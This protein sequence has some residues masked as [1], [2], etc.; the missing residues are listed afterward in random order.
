MV[1]VNWTLLTYLF[2]AL[3]ALGGYFKGWWK[4]AI[5]TVFLTVLV[6][7][8]Q[9]PQVA[10]LLIDLLNWLISTIWQLLPL[11]LQLSI[12]DF[13][14]RGLGIATGGS[15]LQFQA[16]EAQTWIVILVLALAAAILISRLS[17][18]NTGQAAGVYY[19]YVAFWSS[20]LVGAVLGGVNGWLIISLLGAYLDGSKLPGGDGGLAAQSSGVLIQGVEVPSASILDSFLPWL[21]IA[22]GFLVFLAALQSRVALVKDKEGFRKIEFKSPPGHRRHEIS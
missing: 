2:I 7:L 9:L 10:Q 15:A 17:L 18:P 12:S 4:E 21:F 8:L 19:S 16:G 20:N 5:V 11:S 6:L 1:E 14:E 3:F 22:I 13:L